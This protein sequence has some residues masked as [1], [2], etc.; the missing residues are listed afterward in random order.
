MLQPFIDLTN[1][2]VFGKWL[3]M[4]NDSNDK[5]QMTC[6]FIAQMT[7]D[8]SHLNV[9]LAS[10][11]SSGLYYACFTFFIFRLE[12]HDKISTNQNQMTE[13]TKWQKIINNDKWLTK[14][15]KWSNDQIIFEHCLYVISTNILDR[16]LI[17]NDL[18]TWRYESAKN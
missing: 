3:E 10:P 12:S 14:S 16:Q 1:D 17:T 13:M 18:I 5:W 7:N 9:M 11:Y 6:H 15:F 8:P 4:T 2:A